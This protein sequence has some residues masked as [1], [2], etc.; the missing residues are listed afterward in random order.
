MS[1]LE[2][3]LREILQKK[4]VEMEEEKLPAQDE[5]DVYLKAMRKLVNKAIEGGLQSGEEEKIKI[6]C[7]FLATYHDYPVDEVPSR[8]M[9]AVVATLSKTSLA[10]FK[11]EGKDIDPDTAVAILALG[12]TIGRCMAD[13]RLFEYEEGYKEEE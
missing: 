12:Y 13:G 1:L 8:I 11:K 7:R 5:P 3:E 10:I 4:G 6:I 2:D 9:E